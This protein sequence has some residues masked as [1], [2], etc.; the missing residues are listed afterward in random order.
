MAGKRADP[1]GQRDDNRLAPLTDLTDRRGAHHHLGGGR[2]FH[3]SQYA[4]ARSCGRRGSGA[5]THPPAAK[6]L[7]ERP[8]GIVAARIGQRSC[9]VQRVRKTYRTRGCLRSSVRSRKCE[10]A[11]CAFDGGAHV[12]GGVN[13]EAV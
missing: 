7:S 4:S 6:A 10:G 9:D 1:P 8:Y 5:R 13:G 12:E 11:H 3:G 2:G